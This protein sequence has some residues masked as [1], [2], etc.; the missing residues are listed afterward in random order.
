MKQADARALM[1]LVIDLYP[2]VPPTLT[3][4]NPFEIL[5]AVMLSAQTTDV[6]VNAVTRK[7]FADLPTPQLMAQADIATLEGYIDRL[8]L[9]HNKAKYLQTMSRQLVEDFGG[10]VP[11]TRKELTSLAGVGQKTA[12]VVLT[13]AFDVPGVAVDTHVSRIIKGFGLVPQS[14]TPAQIQTYLEKL[15]PQSTWINLH[16]ALIRLGREWLTAVNPKWPPFDAWQPYQ[17]FY[18]PLN[19]A[20]KGQSK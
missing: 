14:S 1:H 10:Q 15:M 7:L 18:R 13:D 2:G 6:A 9:Y 17:Q 20:R 19:Q 3:A 16:R 11:S 5:V 4:N 12:T 8:G